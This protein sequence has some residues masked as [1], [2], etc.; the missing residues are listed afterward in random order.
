MTTK[1]NAIPNQTRNAIVALGLAQGLL[2]LGV[3]LL[4][5]QNILR[6]PADLAWLVPLYAIAIGVPAALQ[7]ILTDTGDRRARLFGLGLAAILAMTGSY[8]GYMVDPSIEDSYGDLVAPYAITTAI[9]WY[10]LLPFVQAYLKSG[11]LRPEYTDLFE[12]AWNN[13]ITL[14]IAKIFTGIFWLLLMLWASLFKVVGI[15]IFWIVFTSKYFTLPVTGV[16]FAFALFLGRSHSG[17]VV[18]VRRVILTVFK[19]LLPLLAL[20]VLLFLF[21]LPVVGLKPLLATGKA[22]ALMLALQI[23]LMIFLNAVYQNGQGEVPY[24]SWLRLLVRAATV[25]LPVYTLLCVYFL[26]LR[27]DQYGWSTDRFWAVLLTVIVGLH[28]FGYAV[29][30]IRQK[31]VWMAGMSTVNV[32]IA[33]V[34]VALAVLVNSPVLDAKGISTASQVAGL[35]DG[36]IPAAEFDYKYLRFDLGRSGNAALA[37]LAELRNHPQAE[38]IRSAA[39]TVAQ[40]KKRWEPTPTPSPVTAQA[41]WHFSVFPKGEHVDESFLT[42]ITDLVAPWPLKRCIER[43]QRCALLL[44]DLNG[45]GRKEYVVFRITDKAERYTAVIEQA[46]NN[47]RL[48]GTLSDTAK[49]PR[50]TQKPETLEELE[51]E[52]AKG[53]YTAVETPWHDLRIGAETRRFRLQQ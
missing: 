3:Q 34:V 8:T 11:R 50:G 32:A 35:L 15:D 20:I 27:I 49:L 37:R 5:Q 14:L 13:L 12:F 24:T 26:S 41:M 31:Q 22:T 47:W 17:A 19:T 45:D 28:V 51:A 33:A 4:T 39:Q 25:V 7:L 38:R 2:L 23:S 36:R 44:V 30:A 43:N 6:A 9:G 10:V 52:L 21:A 53:N 46:D 1:M 16:V 29:A 42:A 48:A 40:Q 18:T